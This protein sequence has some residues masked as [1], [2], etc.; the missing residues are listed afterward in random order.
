MSIRLSE[1]QKHV[2]MFF[3][4]AKNSLVGYM[5]YK[6]NFYSGLIMETVF[7][8]TKLIYIIFVF[9]L[10]IEINGISPDQM[11]I[12]TGTYT[13]M[14]AIYTGLFMDNFYRFAGH[15]RNGTLDLY[16]T[17]PLSLQFMISFRNVNYAF[18][19]PNLIAGIT[20]IVLAWRRLG[21]EPSFIHLAG[22][23][24]V[25]LSSTIVMYSVLLL[26]QILAFWTVKSGSIFDILDKCWDL[27]NMPMYI[28][29]KWLQRIG[30][31][32]VPILFITN[33]PSVYLIDRLDFFLGIWIFAAPVISLLVV[34]LFWKLA[35]RHYESASS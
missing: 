19:I 29:P 23:I 18:P 26:P 8:F 24:G 25:I 31:Y 9:Q 33:M 21:I 4:F 16:M 34:R 10:G 28:Y 15:I 3:I 27:N 14:I 11:M 13:I 5:E 2:R 32:V 35:V 1:I 6:A 20:M 17:K 7:L 30:L 12:F 22:Y